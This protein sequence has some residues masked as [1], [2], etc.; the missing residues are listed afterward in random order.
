MKEDSEIPV[1]ASVHS[2]HPHWLCIEKLATNLLLSRLEA[3]VNGALGPLFRRSAG[4]VV[5]SR[6]SRTQERSLGTNQWACEVMQEEESWRSKICIGTVA[7]K[8]SPDASVEMERRHKFG[9]SNANKLGNH[10]RNGSVP[11]ELQP[12]HTTP[13][14]IARSLVCSC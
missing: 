1:Q 13:I 14:P 12:E 4:P 11:H 2:S 10:V 5:T 8:V 7:R 6:Q 9:R 3:V